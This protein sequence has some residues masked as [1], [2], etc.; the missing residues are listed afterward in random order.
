MGFLHF[1]DGSPATG[2]RY[3]NTASDDYG[4]NLNADGTLDG[5]AWGENIGWVRFPTVFGNPKISPTGQFSGY[6]WGENVG[7]IGLAGLRT[8]SVQIVDTDGDN[9]AD[10]F[11]SLV[12]GL[13]HNLHKNNTV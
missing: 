12:D 7:W 13:P 10:E 5:Y 6:A 9:V 4:V 8:S 11:E 2:H 1:G 3:S